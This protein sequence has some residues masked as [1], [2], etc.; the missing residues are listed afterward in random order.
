MRGKF[1]A[2]LPA[3]LGHEGAGVVAEVGPGVTT[4]RPGD[5]VIPLWRLSCGACEFCRIGRPALCTEGTR[6]RNTGRLVDGT[7]RLSLG[8]RELMHYAGVSTFCEYS[9]VPE[10]AL[11]KIAGDVPLDRAALLGCAVVTG[12]GAVKNAAK[13]K[14]GN[15]VAVFGVGGVGLNVVQGAGLAGCEKIIALDTRRKPL[16]LAHEFGATHTIEASGETILEQVRELTD[17]RGANYVFDTVGAPATLAQALKLARKGGT[18]V[19]TGLSRTDTLAS[20]PLFPFVMQEKRLVGSLYGSGQPLKD[21]PH[22]VSLYQ[23]G[24]L[25]LTELATRTYHLDGINEALAALASAEGA[26]GIICW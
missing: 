26:R 3:V 16:E 15:S 5:G 4:L 9:V 21:I 2:P 1:S 23:E 7:S 17:G 19:V 18:I 24:K 10:A 11:L 8:G 25:K 14:P 12:V 6:I 22:L 20:I 13:V